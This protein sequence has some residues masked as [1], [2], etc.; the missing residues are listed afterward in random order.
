MIIRKN[1]ETVIENLVKD[2][3]LLI[4]GARQVGKTTLLKDISHYLSGRDAEVYEFTLEDP[5][6]LSDL[7]THPD[8]IFH[9]IPRRSYRIYLLLDE[10]QYLKDPSNFLKYHYD[11]NRETI[12]LVVTGS[13]AF[14]IDRGFKDSLAGR[15]KIVELFPF[16]FSEFLTARDEKKLADTIADTPEVGAKR[17]LLKPD[18]RKLQQY[19]REYTVYGGYPKVVLEDNIREKEELLKELVLSFLKKD[20]YEAGVQNEEKF[21][22]LVRMLAAQTGELVNANELSNTLELS[23]DTV[24]KYLY[25]LQKSYII[26]LCSP[27]FRNLRKELT[28][29][30]KVFF[31]DPGYRN[32]LLN[33]FERIDRRVDGGATLE[34]IIFSEMRKNDIEEIGFWRT[35]DK[36]EVDFIVNRSFAYEVK[37]NINKFKINKYKTFLQTYPDIQLKPVT[38]FD[39]QSLDVLDFSG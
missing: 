25:I 32:R 36:K 13:S 18:R 26:R 16:C 2:D 7:N 27:F 10:I 24:A 12:K 29:M 14:Y 11:L 28:K 6:L 39:D 5:E 8:N 15:K 21:F 31:F 38:C 3:I 22:K 4:I 1:R 30:P 33:N 23:K 19:W 20:I 17:K 37:T 9:Y 35:Q 34:N